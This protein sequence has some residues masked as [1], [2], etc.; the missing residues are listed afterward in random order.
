MV[1]AG[2]EER[3]SKVRIPY[4][5]IFPPSLVG[6]DNPVRDCSPVPSSIRG[7][8]PFQRL[9]KFRSVHRFGGF[10]GE[11]L[12]LQWPTENKNL[13]R[14]CQRAKLWRVNGRVVQNSRWMM[15]DHHD[16]KVESYQ[17]IVDSTKHPPNQ[18][19][20]TINKQSKHH[21]HHQHHQSTPFLII[22]IYIGSYS[23]SAQ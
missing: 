22:L 20:S 23:T 12:P 16:H 17:S 18:Q 4:H 9:V 15:D 14:D 3:D 1:A 6:D 19:Q 2:R 10:A 7:C 8:Q 13:P 21:Q 5:S 11:T